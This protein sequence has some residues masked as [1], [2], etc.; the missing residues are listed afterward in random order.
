MTIDCD[1][2]ASRQGDGIWMSSASCPL[3]SG[4]SRNFSRTAC[5]MTASRSDSRSLRIASLVWNLSRV[6]AASS[7]GTFVFLGIDF[8]GVRTGKHPIQGLAVSAHETQQR[9]LAV[10][11]DVGIDHIDADGLAAQRGHVVAVGDDANLALRQFLQSER[12][13]APSD[14]DL[15]GHH[16]SE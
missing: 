4:L 1:S 6:M 15:P 12:R 13:R 8:D 9:V 2:R 16:L 3:L 11:E 10:L 5:A 14:V 7:S